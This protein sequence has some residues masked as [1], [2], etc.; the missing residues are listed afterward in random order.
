MLTG[1]RLCCLHFFNLILRFSVELSRA[2][3][4]AVG[5]IV[6]RLCLQ[7]GRSPDRGVKTA[8]GKM[9]GDAEQLGQV[10]GQE[11][12]EGLSHKL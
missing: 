5:L 12:Q 6:V 8:G 11:T 7:H 1:K 4:F 9:A 3:C 10:D 2:G